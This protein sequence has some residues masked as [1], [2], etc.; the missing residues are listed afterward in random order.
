MSCSSL[1]LV[2]PYFLPGCALPWVLPARL[3]HIRKK[4]HTLPR[5]SHVST[6][7]FPSPH[8]HFRADTRKSCRGVFFTSEQFCSS[9]SRGR[10]IFPSGMHMLSLAGTLPSRWNLPGGQDRASAKRNFPGT[11]DLMRFWQTFVAFMVFYR[12]I[13]L[14]HILVF[15]PIT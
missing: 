10:L 5:N 15:R 9:Q 4:P 13:L 14:P 2:S 1:P 8:P 7:S 6:F 11:Y 3:L 12:R